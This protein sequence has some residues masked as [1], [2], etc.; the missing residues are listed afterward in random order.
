M[1]N[2]T[3][4][5]KKIKTLLGKF[6]V[7]K[8][9]AV[10]SGPMRIL[11]EAVLE[12]DASRKQA[13]QAL[14]IIEAEYVDYNE[15]RASPVKDI[16]ECVGKDFPRI[17]E[18][19]E[20][21]IKALNAICEH[22][23]GMSMEYMEKMTKKDLRRHL[24]EIGLNHYAGSV[25][26]LRAFGGHAVPVDDTLVECLEMDQLIY[27]GSELADVQG[28]LER[29]ISQKQAPA[30][31]EAL[32]AYVESS[33]KALAKKRA[34]EAAEAA[35]KAKAEAEAAAKAEAEAAAKVKAA[36]KAK[37]KKAKAKK[38]KA[39]KPKASK[40][41]VKAKKSAK[42]AAKKSKKTSRAGTKSKALQKK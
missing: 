25:V 36:K 22:A 40:K 19:A 26:T 31:Q 5:Q 39:A 37:A 41:A 1:K 33:A 4:Y 17:R 11:I 38:A 9:A 27:P 13:R 8:V 29:I 23:S 21:V 18:K 24:T 42:P 3:L 28:F 6:K 15:L 7:A 30:A 20:M 16:V 2:A 34:K 35:A 10:G 32:R 12:S 14:D